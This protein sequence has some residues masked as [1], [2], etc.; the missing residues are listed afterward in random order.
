MRS[1]PAGL[2]ARDGWYLRAVRALITGIGGFVGRHL[3]NVPLANGDEVAG[4]DLSTPASAI[5][6]VADVHLG[7]IVNA[8]DVERAITATSPDVIYH[9]AGAASVG[10]SF[11]DPVGTWNVNL[12]G[13]L[14]LLEAVR[15]HS[16]ASRV[17]CVTS[18][19]I[20]GAVSDA[21]L[22][23]TED[24]PLNPHSPYAA[25][26]AAADLAVRQ[27]A[28]GYGL[29]T[30]TVRPFNHIGPGQDPR[31]VV[32]SIAQ[33]IARGERRGDSTIRVGVGNLESRR[34]FMDVRDVAQAYRDIATTGV[35][36]AAYVVST[37][38]SLAISQV[39]EALSQLAQ[40]P[41]QIV[42]E[43][44]RRREGEPL[45]LYG[46]A[47]KLTRDTGWIPKIALRQTLIDT[48][49][50]WRSIAAQEER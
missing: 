18:A 38:R 22:P 32:P 21:N 26:K 33:Q 28:A 27:Y 6:G 47:Q 16:P 44:G 23:V 29:Q 35:A 20:Y 31:F 1:A 36:G 5:D 41:V 19:E 2:Q 50:W 39:V 34:D 30:I 4:F 42:S 49:D 25:S 40:A 24:T 13:T 48:L 7:N 37:G 11:A 46:S 14:T 3:T 8:T 43:P 45:D 12:M 10:A 17:V 15:Q 9:L